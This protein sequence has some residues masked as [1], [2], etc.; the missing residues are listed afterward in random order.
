MFV[1]KADGSVIGGK[2]GLWSGDSLGAALQP[3]D[4]VVV[5][6]KALSG[7]VPWQNILLSAQVASSMA[8]AIMVALHY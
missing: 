5:P 4:M 8:T 3:G 1:I 6:E 7:N 2:N